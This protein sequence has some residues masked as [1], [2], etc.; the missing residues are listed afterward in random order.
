MKRL[1]WSLAILAIAFPVAAKSDAPGPDKK[2]LGIE[3]CKKGTFDC[4]WVSPDFSFSGKTIRVEKFEKMADTPKGD[5]HG[6]LRWKNVDEFMQNVFVEET[7]DRLKNGTKFVAGGSGAY[8]LTGQITEF[9]Y[10]KK[11][12]QRGGWIGSPAGSGAIS[13]DWKIVDKSGKT[14]AAVHHRLLAGA[15]ET[16]DRRVANIHNDEMVDFVK[17]YSK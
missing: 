1:L 9:R 14:V 5:D 6:S 3:D 12:A 15:S 2:F 7:N 10:P 13:Y 4:E 11:G 16:L 17:K 8:T